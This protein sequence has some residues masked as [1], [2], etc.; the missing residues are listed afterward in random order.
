MAGDA[1]ELV[2]LRNN[3][4]RDNYRK[5]VG[6]LLVALIAIV[7]LVG[8]VVYLVMN[9]P[10]P[11]Y[12]AT[13]DSGRIIPL[14]PLGRPMVNDNSLLVWASNAA[15]SA[16][17]FDFLHYRQQL[18]SIDKYFTTAGYH[19]YIQKLNTS[20]N[21]DSVIKKK[22]IVS[23]IPG[24]TPVIQNQGVL[25]GRYAWRIQMPLLVTYH[26]G[27]QQ[28]NNTLMVSMLVVRV[29]TTQNPEGIA[30][31]QINYAPYSGEQNQ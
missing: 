19:D 11:T 29:S 13:T 5:V 23:A 3:F 25:D 10:S 6:A 14:V 9:R 21:L 18:Q 16:Y 8:A 7:A 12:F 22:I 27:G 15:V 17:T 30:I 4:Y 1:L 28:F 2:R 31:A 24:G 26:T 20:G